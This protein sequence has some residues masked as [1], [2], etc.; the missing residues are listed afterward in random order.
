MRTALRTHVAGQLSED[1]VGSQVR[2]CGWIETIR[3]HGGLLFFH[4]RDASGKLQVVVDPED[5]GEDVWAAAESLHIEDCVSFSGKLIR[6]PEGMDRTS[7]D[8]KTIEL[9]AQEVEVLNHSATPPFKPER[10]D[11]TSEEVRLTHRYL[12]LRSDSLQRALRTRAR[13]ISAMRSHL[14]G[15]EFLEVETPLL[16]RST[17]E[18]ARDFLIPSRLNPGNFYALPQSPQIFK[19][20]LMIGGVDRYY[21][22]AK[23][24]RDEDL[25]A[26]R[27]PEFTQLDLEMSFVEEEDV[28][29]LVEGLLESVGQAIGREIAKPFPRLSYREAIDRYG[30]DAP[31]TRFGMEIVDLTDLFVYSNFRIFQRYASSGGSVR[32]ILVPAALEPTRTEREAVRSYAKNHLGVPEPAWARMLSDGQFDSTVAKFSTQEEIQSVVERMG[33]GVDD[34][35]FFMAG[36]SADEVCRVLGRIRLFI[37]ERSGLR[38][39][40]GPLAFAW[41]HGFPM[42]ETEPGTDRLTSVHHPFTRPSELEVLQK[43]DRDQLLGLTARAY[44]LVLNGEEIGGGSLRIYQREAQQKVFELLQ[45]TEDEIEDRFGFFLKALEFGAPPHGG[46]AFGLDRMASIFCGRK[47][48]RDVIAFPKNQAGQCL[49]TGAPGEVDAEQLEELR[50]TSLAV[51]EMFD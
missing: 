16:A 41:V 33:G 51:E 21:Q 47:S 42:F 14:D 43:G 48:I 32:G 23:C 3:D 24:L 17:P 28:Y 18:G 25:R 45:L 31:D 27:Q 4:L 20:I 40:D 5:V 44:D 7:L 10:P 1:Q 49:L 22:I 36:E 11:L 2:L 6:R 29:G 35:I 30:T 9:E 37:A 19:Q 38:P 34:V 50:I 13:M 26:N 12:D 8:T 15:H 46:I 39:L